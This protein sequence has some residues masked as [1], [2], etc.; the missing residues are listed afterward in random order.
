MDA[1][2]NL[3]VQGKVLYLGI[4]DAPAWVVA[5]A[6]SYAEFHGKT[7]FVIYQGQW[8]VLERSFEREIIPMARS[9]GLAL[10]PWEVVGGGKFRSD[11]EDKERSLRPS[12]SDSEEIKGHSIWGSWERTEDEIKVS[13]ALEEVANEIGANSLRAV[14]IAYILHKA[15]YVFPIIGGRKPEHLV[16]N[17]EALDI[18]LSEEHI[19]F[20]E[21][22]VPFGLGFPYTVIKITPPSPLPVFRLN[23]ERNSYCSAPGSKFL[24]VKNV[25]LLSSSDSSQSPTKVQEAFVLAGQIFVQG[26]GSHVALYTAENGTTSTRALKKPP[27]RWNDKE[28]AALIKSYNDQ[29]PTAEKGGGY[30][31]VVHETAFATLGN[32]PK[33]QKQCSNKLAEVHGHLKKEWNMVTLIKEQSGFGVYTIN[34]GAGITA[35]TEEIWQVFEWAH[36]ECAKWKNKGPW[37]YDSLTPIMPSR[38]KGTNIFDASD[39]TTHNAAQDNNNENNGREDSEEEQQGEQESAEQ[40]DGSPTVWDEA[41]MDPEY[42]DSR[43]D[44]PSQAVTAQ[45]SLSSVSST[46]TTA[47]ST[48]APKRHAPSST[49]AS[50]SSKKPHSFAAPSGAIHIYER[51]VGQRCAWRER[52]HL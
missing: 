8:N 6:N 3:I 14:A 37:W 7:P 34:H 27:N 32:E 46:A 40:R 21:G 13:R 50:S 28:L 20:L 23:S 49:P 41:A 30:K 22:I 19:K 36:P 10:A 31:W 5:Q 29:N 39:P 2:H 48:P 52:G 35:E 12:K 9:L 45:T 33:N 18:T 15:P 17:L 44:L 51:G 26:H 47:T 4:S 25:A 43:D 11:E 1:L 38:A 16:S 42:D 24:N